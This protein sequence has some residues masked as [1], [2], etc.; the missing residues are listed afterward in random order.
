MKFKKCH[1]SWKSSYFFVSA[2]LNLSKNAKKVSNYFCQKFSVQFCFIRPLLISFACRKKIAYARC[3]KGG[4]LLFRFK[5]SARIA[6]AQQRQ[7]VSK[8]T[9]V[10]LNGTRKMIIFFI[11]WFGPFKM[12]PGR[13]PEVSNDNRL[14]KCVDLTTGNTLN[15]GD[16]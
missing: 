3:A 2:L 14:S 4:A 13:D 6:R 5:S 16:F 11:M 9:R 7:R 12:L 10:Q 1:H 15:I 8:L